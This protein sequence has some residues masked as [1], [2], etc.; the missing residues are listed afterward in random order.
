[1]IIFS[2][3]FR[4]FSF[5]ESKD[6]VNLHERDE[7]DKSLILREKKQKGKCDYLVLEIDKKL[8]KKRNF[9][10]LLAE[11]KKQRFKNCYI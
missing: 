9:I 1:M 5:F 10:I 3:L 4:E 2:L 6:N 11:K 7:N 8:Q